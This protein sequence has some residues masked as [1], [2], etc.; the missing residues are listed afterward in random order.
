L[1]L[2]VPKTVTTLFE[3]RAPEPGE[4]ILTVGLVRSCAPWVTAKLCPAIRTG[5]FRETPPGLALAVT[6]T[7][8]LPVPEPGAIV[9][10][11]HGLETVQLQ[12]GPVLTA[13]IVLPPPDGALQLVGLI[14]KVPEPA[15]WLIRKLCP[16]IVSVQLRGLQLGLGLAQ[17]V[18]D[19]L[20]VPP[21]GDTV[22]QLHAMLIV[23]LQSLLL[24]VRVTFV[25]P[26]SGDGLQFVGLMANVP[27]PAS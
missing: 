3:T 11:P 9:S 8:P 18:S 14:M 1:S 22:S 23:Q 15:D 27:G 26:P 19:R 12:P 2:A 25:H 5:Q 24:A 13:T 21:L 4:T 7:E 6:V 17:R 16:A 10:H 20:P